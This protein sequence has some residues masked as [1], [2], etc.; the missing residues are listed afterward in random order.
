MASLFQ[1]I[2]KKAEK[3][4]FYNWTSRS[5]DWYYDKLRRHKGAT[6]ERM[7]KDEKVK[8][9]R[10]PLLGRV[11]FFKYDPKTKADMPY[12]D[13]FPMVIMLERTKK[14][15]VGL[16][17]HYLP[18]KIRAMFFD[19][20]METLNNNKLDESTKFKLTYK[21]LKA[22]SKYRAFAPCYKNYL[23]SHVRSNFAEIHPDEWEMAM[24]LPSDQFQKEKRT[25]VWSD[26]RKIINKR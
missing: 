5:R 8:N 19:T 9:K 14:G 6:P 15:F 26:S 11:F 20:V 24:F 4:R 23:Y 21:K 13:T 17:L 25:T 12:Y 1:D 10:R 22:A 3:E 16:N 2:H 7:L 18:P